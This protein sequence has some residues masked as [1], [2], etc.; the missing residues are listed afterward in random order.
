M[1]MLCLLAGHS[2]C[3]GIAGLAVGVRFF[4]REAALLHKLGLITSLFVDMAIEDFFLTAAQR[5]LRLYAVLGMGMPLCHLFLFAGEVMT[6]GIASFAVGVTFG[7]LFFF[8]NQGI[9]RHIALA[10][11]SM[12][13]AHLRCA[14]NN[15]YIAIT[16]FTMRMAGCLC[17]SAGQATVGGVT[18]VSMFVSLF[19]GIAGQSRFFSIATVIVAVGSCLS[20]SASQ[21]LFSAVAAFIVGM[22]HTGE[23]TANAVP[24]LIIAAG[25][26]HMLCRPWLLMGLIRRGRMAFHALR[27]LRQQLPLLVIA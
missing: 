3:L 11:V 9:F 5:G 21:L 15:L 18:A 1:D 6:E 4:R 13:F 8:T 20:L 14:G 12:A 19:L 17:F 26:M 23:E 24:L 10:A 2:D 7:D 22:Y 27:Q 25:A 16:A